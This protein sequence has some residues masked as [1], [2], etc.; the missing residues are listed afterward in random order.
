M[1]SRWVRAMTLAALCSG[2]VACSAPR[3]NTVQD[4]MRDPAKHI[5]QRIAMAGEIEQVISPTAF[6][7]EDRSPGGREILVLTKTPLS[8]SVQPLRSMDEFR[9]QLENQQVRVR[10]PVELFSIA[11]AERRLQTDLDDMALR[12]YEGRLVIFADDIDFKR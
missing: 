2:Y 10:G 9:M 4:V 11:E 3:A 1:K 12:Q 6:V 7:M 8:P 5:G